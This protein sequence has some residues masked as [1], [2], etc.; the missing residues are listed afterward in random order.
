MIIYLIF[1]FLVSIGLSS[2]STSGVIQSGNIESSFSNISLSVQPVSTQATCTLYN[3]G[4]AEPC[5]NTI[6]DIT[7]TPIPVSVVVTVPTDAPQLYTIVNYTAVQLPCIVDSFN[8]V[9]SPATSCVSDTDDLDLRCLVVSPSAEDAIAFDSST[10]AYCF[11]ATVQVLENDTWVNTTDVVSNAEYGIMQ[12][13]FV[14]SSLSNPP[15]IIPLASVQVFLG[16]FLFIIK[17]L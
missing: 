5:G 9:A 3:N 1:C 16:M 13:R 6:V 11:D 7:P 10:N 15:E 12:F 4:D 8:P 17:T 2:L 14:F